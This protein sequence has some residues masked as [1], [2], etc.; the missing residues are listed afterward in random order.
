MAKKVF[1]NTTLACSL[2]DGSVIA[3]NKCSIS[4]RPN[5][6]PLIL[7]D[8]TTDSIVASVLNG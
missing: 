5:P 8:T 3:D 7:D 2:Q 4:F 1:T 6:L